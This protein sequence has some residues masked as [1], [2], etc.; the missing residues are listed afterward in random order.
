MIKFFRKIRQNLLSEKK[1][2]KY[3]LYAIGE[4]LL[5][6]IGILIA[7]Q[8]NLKQENISNQNKIDK[9][10][11]LLL[12]D[13]E[14]DKTGVL[15]CIEFDSLKVENIN[16]YID[17]N[18]LMLNN[19]TLRF[20]TFM[21]NFTIH[22]TTYNSIQLNNVFELIKD[23]E[24]QKAISEYYS[25]AESVRDFEQLELNTQYAYFLDNLL[26]NK[27]LVQFYHHINNNDDSI[28]LTVE[29]DNLFYGYLVHFRDNSNAELKRYNTLTIE[30]EKLNTL[31][32][33]YKK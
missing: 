12:K 21:E 4:I 10:L 32:E 15:K 22:N 17:S 26:K 16:H 3:L 9:Y 33:R 6:V 27:R 14:K 11:S 28:D 30:I 31:L 18:G 19:S 7:L 1:Y 8:L 23:I 20:A 2:S 25:Y 13:L 24:I 5:V 29:E